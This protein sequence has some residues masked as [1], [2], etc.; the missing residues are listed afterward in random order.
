[1][2]KLP[3]IVW[4][5]LLVFLSGAASMNNLAIKNKLLVCFSLL[6]AAMLVVGGLSIWKMSH[7][8]A[9]AQYLGVERRKMLEVTKGI[10]TAVSDY[11]LAEAGHVLSVGPNGSGNADRDRV[12]Q[13]AVVDDGI[14]FLKPRLVIPKMQ[15]LVAQ[16]QA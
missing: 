12:A 14:A 9:T 6:V 5:R 11:R 10:D 15:A 7:L 8:G 2:L 1:M 16:F 3:V 4:G 13:K